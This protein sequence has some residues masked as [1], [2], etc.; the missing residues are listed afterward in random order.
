MNADEVYQNVR[1]ALGEVLGVDETE[2]TPQ[3]TVVGDLEA[4]SLDIVD[5]LFQLKK[6]FSIELT[7]AEVQREL[8]PDSGG[9]EAD[10]SGGEGFNDALFDKVTVQDVTNWVSARLPA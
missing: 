4:T 9:G 3:A 10:D 8:L 5:L 7:L 1:H 6:M 2:I